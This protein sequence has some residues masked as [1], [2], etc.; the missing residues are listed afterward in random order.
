MRQLTTTVLLC[1]ALFA[2]P[3]FSGPGHEHGHSHG[4]VS[5]NVAAKKATKK[6]AQLVK[7]GK[8]DASWKSIKPASVEQK[9]YAK[10]P[11]WVIIFNNEKLSDSSKKTLYM[12]F[13]L[14]GR[15]IAANYTGN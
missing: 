3:V 13:S 6:L 8:I 9:E 1:S 11:E 10:G 14:D 5:S 12:F 15:Y 7:A 4:P 2:T